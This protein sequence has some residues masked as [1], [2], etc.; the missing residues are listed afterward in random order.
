MTHVKAALKAEN[1]IMER[2]NQTGYVLNSIVWLYLA[3][4]MLMPIKLFGQINTDVSG[5]YQF[6]NSYYGESIL[7]KPDGRFIYKR[8]HQLAHFEVLG[9]WQLRNDSII[10]DS[11]PQHDRLIVYESA[12]KSRKSVVHVRDKENHLFTYHLFYQTVDNRD[13]VMKDQ[14]N[15]SEIPYKVKSFY[16]IDVN[17]M[18]SPV[19]LV[20]GSKSNIFNVLFETNKVFE[21][22]SWAIDKNKIQPKRD[23]GENQ[24]YRLTPKVID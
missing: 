20:K 18:K 10:L 17:G 5:E 21:N 14:W 13:Y 24:N 6:S 3:V 22:E 2:N 12:K 19:Y 7:L 1:R 8:R 15:Q 11:Y 16:V 4:I 23:D 9:N